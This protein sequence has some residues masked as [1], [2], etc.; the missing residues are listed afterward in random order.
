[1]S[2]I[3]IYLLDKLNNPKEE[4]NIAKPDTY[5]LL[6][7]QVKQNLKNIPE[8]YE[9]F[10]IDKNNK[11]IKI[12]NEETYK[13][14]EDILFIREIDYN[15]LQQSLFE[16]NYNRLSESQQEILNEKYN[17]ILCTMTIKNEKPYFCYKCQNIF[18]EKCLRDWDKKCK[19]Q[20]KI[21]FCPTCRNELPLEKWN[22]KLNYEENRK[23]NAFLLNR[24]NAYK[25]NNN[26]N[27]NINRIK[28]KKISE[29]KYNEIR[30][31]QL[32]KKYEQYI[33]KAIEIFKN[34]IIQINSI[35]ELIKL[36]DDFKLD[37][38][39]DKYPL[40]FP[41][42]GIDNL[43]KVFNQEFEQFK[44]YIMN[45]NK[46]Y[47]SQDIKKINNNF[48]LFDNSQVII[49]NSIEKK[50][51]N[52]NKE[53]KNKNEIE[54]KNEFKI[55]EDRKYRNEINLIYEAKL[56]DNYD[57]FGKEFVDNN[58]GNIDLIINDKKIKLISNCELKEGENTIKMIIKHKLIDLSYMFYWCSSLK[59]ISELKY[60]DVSKCTNFKYMFHYCRLL[61]DLK[62]LEYWDVS[63]G[64]S[65][66]SM[67]WGCQ[68]LSDIKA[69]QNWNFRNNKDFESMFSGCS[70]L[71][72]ITPL[73]N[74]NVSNVK[75]FESCF[76]DVYL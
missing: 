36:G 7:Q 24:I 33:D 17:C 55:E 1:M 5:L 12:N 53:N 72:D 59:D 29:L 20:N 25:M 52:I 49:F 3:D 48:S 61:S 4:I 54:I 47:K 19:L 10:I 57:I 62:P 27:N 22:K 39:A 18:H 69:L 65:F 31:N 16:M 21:L 35:R 76:L 9:V 34:I 32:I 51:V 41:D 37:N 63:N 44:I 64:T 45:N 6:L 74:W 56:T 66:R 15:L 46:K 14:I 60:L 43:S 11:E 42:I 28:E 67:F 38:F 23:D 30:Q 50:N 8:Y 40:N 70:A 13:T 73:Q 26:L 2:K 71:T 75:I 58:K 68:S